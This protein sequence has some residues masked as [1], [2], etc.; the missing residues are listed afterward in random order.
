MKKEIDMDTEKAKLFGFE[1]VLLASIMLI[2]PLSFFILLSIKT[3][4]PFGISEI[5]FAVVFS[6]IATLL[7]LWIKSIMRKNPYTGI[8]IG[9]LIL[10]ISITSLFYRFSGPY[11]YA[12]ASAAGIVVLAY[13]G[14]EFY[15]YR[16]RNV[17][18][19]QIDG[20]I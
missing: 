16:K 5:L 3:S 8:V 19:E 7:L 17:G 4:A 13:L 11:T 12:H 1:A 10:V 15:R 20:E 9:V 18:I 6:I 2:I 14:I